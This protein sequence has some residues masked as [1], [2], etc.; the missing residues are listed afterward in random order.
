MNLKILNEL[1]RILKNNPTLVTNNQSLCQDLNRL[2]FV[3][4]KR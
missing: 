1:D 4:K 3:M 2:Y